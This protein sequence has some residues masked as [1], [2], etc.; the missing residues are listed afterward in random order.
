MIKFLN[1]TRFKY[2]IFTIFLSALCQEKVNQSSE[3]G[4]CYLPQ[5]TFISLRSRVTNLLIKAIEVETNPLNTQMLLG[6]YL[7]LYFNF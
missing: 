2:E 6:G 1:L 3:A 5:I 7:C 4:N